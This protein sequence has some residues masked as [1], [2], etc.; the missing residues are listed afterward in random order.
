MQTTTLSKAQLLHDLAR[1]Y[2]IKGLGEKNF[3]AIPYHENVVLRAPLRPGGS[4]NP[5]FGKES[6]RQQ[7]WAPLPSLLGRVKFIDSFVSEDCTA[8]TAEF[9]CEI[10]NPSCV[11]RV[12]DRF[13]ITEEG[14][15]TEQ[16]NF[17]DPRDVT[18]P[19]SKG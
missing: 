1:D 18:N 15:I 2:V 10:L 8:V 6:L 16:E 19:G 11:L 5:L 17:F 14:K 13:I 12:I 7:W 3:D 4:E 9:H